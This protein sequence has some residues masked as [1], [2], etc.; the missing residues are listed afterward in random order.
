MARHLV[1]VPL[2]SL[3]EDRKAGV[4]KLQTRAPELNENDKDPAFLAMTPGEWNG[5]NNDRAFLMVDVRA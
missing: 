1:Q 4:A 5:N 2:D 3:S